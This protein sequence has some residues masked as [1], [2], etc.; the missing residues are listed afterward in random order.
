V[1]HNT[2]LVIKKFAPLFSPRS[3]AI[4]GA[5]QDSKKWGFRML[6]TLINGGFQGKIYPVNPDE[7]EILGLKAYASITDI[8]ET[9]D[10]VVIVV[11]TVH[12]GQVVKECVNKRVKAG[13]IIA[14]GFAELGEKGAQLQQKM[15][16]TARGGGMVLV[17]PNCNGI[18]NPKEKLYI[19]FPDFI[20]PPGPLAVIAQSGNIV[21]SVARQIMLRGFGCS[22]C[23]ASGNEADL[24]SEDYIEYLAEEPN[25]KV[26][27]S[28]I[29]GFKDGQRFLDIASRVSKKK[30][31]VMVKAGTT[32][33]GAKA[34]MSHTASI[35]G[36]S[37][38]FDAACKQYGVIRVRNLDDLVNV[39][40][41][42]LN[43]PLPQGRKV[44]IVT[45]GG[46]WG[47]LGADSCTEL[48][49][50][51]ISLPE[52]TIEE[53]DSILPPWW[54]RA[55]PVDLVAGSSPTAIFKAV[56]LVLSCTSV[57][58]LLMLSMMNAVRFKRLS[59]SV[60][61]INK[62]RWERETIEA[63]ANA[64]DRFNELAKKYQKPVIIASEQMWANAVQETKLTY[65]LG[66]RN[67]ICY[68][69]PHQAA[70]VL[71]SLANY[72]EYLGRK[73]P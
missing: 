51:V 64:V 34:A 16:D 69:H 5:S 7:D 60:G 35:A 73:Q 1:E 21:D 19:Q 46:G 15:V 2:D 30:P 57:D 23:I 62:E 20:T 38:V 53:L 54:N 25:T 59:A 43:Q 72:N 24:H 31:I 50:E 8:P 14:A 65:A 39:G 18:I 52:K 10:L 56:E 33:A 44:G 9:P 49:L 29:E 13:I 22:L 68:Q 55:N 67:S 6:N 36:S 32:Q 61:E 66:Q 47:V 12:V 40:I 27:L 17:G 37:S 41:A 26:I 45:G 11:P 48:G 71:A 63:T 3:V 58:G 4:V 42:L 70:T 28:Y